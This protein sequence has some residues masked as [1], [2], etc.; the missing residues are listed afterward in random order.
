MLLKNLLLLMPPSPLK[1]MAAAC[2]S[3]LLTEAQKISA[4][5]QVDCRF[6]Q[7]LLRGRGNFKAF[8]QLL[9]KLQ[10]LSEVLGSVTYKI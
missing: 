1:R 10:I 7:E 6:Q 2:N 8:V 3:V 9:F 4:L 5:V